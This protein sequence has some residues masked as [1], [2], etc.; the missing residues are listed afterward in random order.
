M[1]TEQQ[2]EGMKMRKFDTKRLVGLALFTAIVV[3]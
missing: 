2:Q 3:V 1:R